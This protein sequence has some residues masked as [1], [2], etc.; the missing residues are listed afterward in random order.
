MPPVPSAAPP[1]RVALARTIAGAVDELGTDLTDGE[2]TAFANIR[3]ALLGGAQVS[4]EHRLLALK[5]LASRAASTDRSDLVVRLFTVA[6]A[7]APDDATLIYDIGNHLAKLGRRDDAVA[8][9][10]RAVA[11]DPAFAQALYNRGRLVFD[12]GRVDDGIADF[13]AAAR[14]GLDLDGYHTS[15]AWRIVPER[16]FVA[17]EALAADESLP[18]DQRVGFYRALAAAIA[19]AEA[20]G[21]WLLLSPWDTDEAAAGATLIIRAHLADIL[22]ESPLEHF[23]DSI[24][25]GRTAQGYVA[26]RLTEE[27]I[28]EAVWYR[29]ARWGV[30]GPAPDRV[31]HLETLDQFA[32]LAEEAGALEAAWAA[33]Y[34]AGAIVLST[35]LDDG[36]DRSA[37][38]NRLTVAVEKRDDGTIVPAPAAVA[39]VAAWVRTRAAPS[40]D[41]DPHN[42][43]GDTRDLLARYAAGRFRAAAGLLLR[44]RADRTEPPPGDV[45]LLDQ[46][47]QP[48]LQGG[49]W[50]TGSGALDVAGAMWRSAEP[51][52]GEWV[53]A[54]NL[55]GRDPVGHLA[56][57]ARARQFNALTATELWVD[58]PPRQWREAR[59]RVIGAY[60]PEVTPEQVS[61]ALGPGG[62]LLD[63]YLY[64]IV[65]DSVIR[66]AVRDGAAEVTEERVDA[67]AG[68]LRLLL[69]AHRPGD[70]PPERLSG[71]VDELLVGGL[72][73]RLAGAGCL[74]VVPFGYLR[75]VP[76]HALAS[77]HAAVEAGGI[78]RIAYLPSTSF[79][80]RP[81]VRP[82]PRRRCLFVGFDPS[83]VLDLDGELAAVRETFDD[84]TVLRD[85]AATVDAVLDAFAGHDVLHVAC[86]GDVN[87]KVRAGYLELAGGRMY[88]WHLMSGLP[89]PGAVVLNA[90]LTGTTQAFEPTS[91]EAFGLHT[92][93]LTAG[94]GWVVGGLWEVNDWSAQHFTRAFYPQWMAGG[95]AAAA[96]VGSQAAMRAETDD[97]VLWAPHALFGDWR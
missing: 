18:T 86:H 55:V 95:S 64:E 49:E 57:T 51:V 65:E 30:G 61:A 77:V 11:I 97:A 21:G 9:Y 52:F 24:H 50:A 47:D 3:R 89:V 31:A 80:A 22:R 46:N 53:T 36:R 67:L 69:E 60:D 23:V 91:D 81:P 62:L 6:S 83:G 85:G 48:I 76:F 71:R 41:G 78:T 92:A 12:S 68:D 14:A 28:R 27:D 1:D 66:L 8:A 88:P 32:D 4:L 94:A 25:M 42:G 10:D 93:F 40:G 39:A 72:T 26:R 58:L 44:L 84:V 73:D 35:L 5:A 19:Q 63:S 43:Q 45:F 7:L 16:G 20:F 29:P 75:N 13:V 34:M 17:L 59:A 37:P 90:C 79:L 33:H 38:V 15:V 56:A 74:V 2:R 87:A 96:V 70:L 82:G 54:A